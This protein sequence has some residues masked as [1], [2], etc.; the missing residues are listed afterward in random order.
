M[1]LHVGAPCQTLVNYFF[2]I[3]GLM[4]LSLSLKLRED[5]PFLLSPLV[6]NYVKH[7]WEYFSVISN[8]SVHPEV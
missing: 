4:R 2:R 6:Y 1:P 5:P 3:L 8:L 7:F